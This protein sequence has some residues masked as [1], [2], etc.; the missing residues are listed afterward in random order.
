MVTHV[1]YGMQYMTLKHYICGRRCQTSLSRASSSS[2]SRY[3]L[4]SENNIT[5]HRFASASQTLMK[6]FASGL[7]LLFS[8]SWHNQG[9]LFSLKTLA[10]VVDES[11]VGPEGGI[12]VAGDSGWTEQRNCRCRR[13]V[14]LIEGQR[15]SRMMKK[16]FVS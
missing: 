10:S 4:C 6:V 2:I 11:E 7:I 12:S 8:L 16:V 14:G 5:S 1:Y 9:L 15:L 13:W 3:V